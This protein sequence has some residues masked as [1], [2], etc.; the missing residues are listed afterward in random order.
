[1]TLEPQKVRFII[2]RDRVLRASCYSPAN[3][4]NEAK[5]LSGKKSARSC[6]DD[7]LMC[8]LCGWRSTACAFRS[9]SFAAL[10]IQGC[11]PF[12]QRTCYA[13]M[14]HW[15]LP[16]HPPMNE[17]YQAMNSW[18][19]IPVAKMTVHLTLN[20]GRCRICVET[21]RLDD[22]KIIIH[23]KWWYLHDLCSGRSQTVKQTE[24]TFFS[25]RLQT[26]KEE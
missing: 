25:L 26:V 21:E 19:S 1:M 14:G 3:S 11:G 5:P 8:T 4:A 12:F 15:I 18:Y 9:A 22:T 6:A 17:R 7:A 23:L 2:C 10:H 20:T 13:Y 24:R 16:L